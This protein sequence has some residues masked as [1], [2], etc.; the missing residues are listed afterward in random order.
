MSALEPTHESLRVMAGRT[1]WTRLLAGWVLA[2]AAGVAAAGMVYGAGWW[3]G[4]PWEVDA[5]TAADAMRA[6]W[7][8]IIMLY[9][10]IFGTN[11]TLAPLVAIAALVLY[12]AGRVSVAVH[13]A[14]VQLGSWTLNPALKFSV[15][16]A[17]PDLFEQRGQHAFPAFP[18]GHVIAVVAVLFTVA[19]LIH[20]S[21]RGTWGYWVV[22]VFFLINSFSRVYLQ[23]HWP[24]DVLA[25][26]VV[27]G[28][29]LVWTLGVFAPLHSRI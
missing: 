7:L 24:T 12:R 8:D 21:G 10:P 9:L 19:W 22:G 23:V 1:P 14:V 5:L 13:L 11:Y 28:V 26:A 27:G 25:G 3:G 18:S 29:W 20:R 6:G 17:R 16:R 2:Y 15:P 4:A